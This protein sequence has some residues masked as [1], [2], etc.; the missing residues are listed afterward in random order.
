MDIFSRI[1]FDGVFQIDGKEIKGHLI[2]DIDGLYDTENLCFQE[3]NNRWTYFDAVSIKLE[4]DL[5]LNKHFAGFNDK[6]QKITIFYP[7]SLISGPENIEDTLNGLPTKP[8][9]LCKS[10][11]MMISKDNYFHN[12]NSKN[13]P[14]FDN[15]TLEFKNLD[16]F[17]QNISLDGRN[18][19]SKIIVKANNKCYSMHIQYDEAVPFSL[20]FKTNLIIQD[21]ISIIYGRPKYIQNVYCIHDKIKYELFY[22]Q[23]RYD[24]YE[25][26]KIEQSYF[27][28]QAIST[29][30][31]KIIHMYV[32]K[33]LFN[34]PYVTFFLMAQYFNLY[35]PI[36]YL[37]FVESL[38][39]YFELKNLKETQNHNEFWEKRKYQHKKNDNEK[40]QNEEKSKCHMNDKI[41][42][43]P[44][45]G[46]KIEF[47]LSE[48]IKDMN[49]ND[50]ISYGFIEK[51]KNTRI[52]MAHSGLFADRENA[53]RTEHLPIINE[54][55]LLVNSYCIF[56]ELELENDAIKM[57]MHK[58][59]DDTIQ[60]L[61]Y[62]KIIDKQ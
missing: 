54:L 9:T 59:L 15:I 44:I 17:S 23:V 61:E 37:Y 62:C 16:D 53:F 21:I 10:K 36:K 55:L 3:N 13:E 38:E 39:A 24:R 48:F 41:K 40:I 12:I 57:W 28:I 29:H 47:I 52:F 56:K 14:I 58:K 50:F 18:E 19:H 43:K 5:I 35:T 30:F 27:G 11:L 2:Y 49:I 46:T 22:S 6:N 60:T 51:I 7:H 26:R 25:N 32:T 33:Q 8:M 4:C 42:I 20:H 31:N 34:K 45:F 1:E